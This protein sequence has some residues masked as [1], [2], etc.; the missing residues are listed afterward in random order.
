MRNSVK[1]GLFSALVFPGTGH[2]VLRRWLRGLLFCLPTFAAC[3]F[4]VAFSLDRALDTVDQILAGE[5]A[6]DA[7]SIEAAL[8]LSSTRQQALLLVCAQSLILACWL[9]GIAD[10]AYL[11]H[12]ADTAPPTPD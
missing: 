6:A 12:R 9:A 3:V 5:V 10:A 8:R 1:A 4:L 11:G 7:A 2:F